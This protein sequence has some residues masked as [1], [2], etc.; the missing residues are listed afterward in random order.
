MRPVLRNIYT[1]D[2]LYQL[3]IVNAY[4]D[5]C[6]IAVSYCRRDN[7]RAVAAVKMQLKAGEERWKMWLVNFAQDKTKVMVVSRTT[8]I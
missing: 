7:R 8:T 3:P 2:L 5:E 1:D 6:N 4:A